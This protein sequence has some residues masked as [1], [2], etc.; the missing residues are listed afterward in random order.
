MRTAKR[1][2]GTGDQLDKLDAALRRG[3][4]AWPA[5]FEKLGSS[6]RFRRASF[7]V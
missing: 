6:C 7:D 3:A 5:P 1:E 2:Q 4:A